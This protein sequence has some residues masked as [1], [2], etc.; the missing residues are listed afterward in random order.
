MAKIINAATFNRVENAT[1][2]EIE[3]AIIDVKDAINRN[4]NS[5]N[6]INRL[7]ELELIPQSYN[8]CEVTDPSD[9]PTI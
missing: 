8:I 1:V 6:I 2:A 9:F 3:Q 7:D 4:S 5:A